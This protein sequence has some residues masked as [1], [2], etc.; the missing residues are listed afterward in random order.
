MGE[1]LTLLRARLARRGASPPL[2]WSYRPSSDRQ[3]SQ[4][5]LANFLLHWFPSRALARSLSWTYSFW[6]GTIAATSMLLLVLTG[7]P[8]LFFYV[9]SVER[10]Y[11]SI[12]DIEHVVSFGS[13]IRSMHRFSA[14]L[15]VAA[16]FAHIVRVFLTGAYKNGAPQVQRRQ[17]NWVIGVALLLVTLL[18]SFSGYLLPWDQ[19]A[20]WAVTIGTNIAVEI[21]LVGRAIGE[22][23]IGGRSIDQATLIRFYVLH[24]FILPAIWTVLFCYHVWR[25]RKDGGLACADQIDL[26]AASPAAPRAAARDSIRRRSA[27]RGKAPPAQQASLDPPDETLNASPNLARR[28]A[29]VM[30]GT[31]ALL[32]I[33]AAL[34]AS[35]LGAPAN[36]L[37]TP[38]PAKSPWYFLWLQE[39]VTDTTIRLGSFTINGALVG[40]VALPGAL[41]L[42]TTIWPWVDRSPLRTVGAWWPKERRRQSIVCLLVVAVMVALTLVGAFMRGPGWSFYW[43]WQAWPGL[44][45]RF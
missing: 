20:F 24:V 15:M 22:V 32:G 8:L 11:G 19:L 30:L 35:P 2:F 39:I 40:G 29:V 9:P 12:K 18:L 7:V 13:W 10:A 34:V 26:V 28:L 4:A 1:R 5:I 37:V 16:V 21:P 38:N 14:H 17:W 43:P 33:V 6:L 23:L 36:P 41:L 25:I 45:T 31:T 27:K 3:A 44:P 42:L